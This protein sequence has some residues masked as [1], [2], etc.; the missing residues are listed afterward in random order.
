MEIRCV[1]DVAAEIPEARFIRKANVEYLSI[2]LLDGTAPTLEQLVAGIE[3]IMERIERGERVLVH[4]A[5][6]H[7]R[8]TTFTAA[9]L[10]RLNRAETPEEALEFCARQR[11]KIG[12]H[13]SQKAILKEFGQ[14]Q[15]SPNRSSGMS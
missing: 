7:G 15:A 14:S 9:V 13:S 2:P 10:M 5:M 12:L 4:C 11:P 3:W 1:L 6:G 8:S